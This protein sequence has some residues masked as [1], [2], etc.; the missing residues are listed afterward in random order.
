MLNFIKRYWTGFLAILL[1]IVSVYFIYEKL[2]QKKIPSYLV[3]GTGHIDGDLI[4]L[5]VKYPSR[6][7]K[8]TIDD[9]DKIKKG[10]LIAKLKSKEYEAKKEQIQKEIEAQQKLLKAKEIELNISKTTI[11][12]K[13]LKAKYALNSAQNSL[14]AFKKE[15][16]L[17]KNV[18][19]Q[20]KKDYKRV[21]NLY[22]D[23]LIE[24][25][26]LEIAKLKLKTEN[27][28]LLS[29]LEK[30]KS[31]IES[32]K[33][34]KSN[35]IDAQA[36]QKN[37]DILKESINALTFK[38][39]TLKKSKQE[40]EVILDEMKLY[41][42]IDG[43]VVEKI[44][45]VGEVLNSGMSVATLIDPKSLYLKIFVDTIKNGK[46]KIGDKALIFL[47]AY[48]NDPIKARVTKIAQ[49]AEFTP[50]EVNVRSD[51]IQ[52]V[53]AVYLKPLKPNPLL[54]LGLPAI[55]VISINGKKLPKSLN[56]LPKL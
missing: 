10:M 8:I 47:D 4:N 14:N 36:A 19:S 42:P 1:I 52:R 33:I 23:R 15:I 56:E 13:L 54:K 7:E 20:A 16:D 22:K 18:L 29:M 35:L 12:Q 11:S 38:I 28:K 2:H 5:N 27:D 17:Q 43:Y 50:K 9:G 26:K 6:V 30:Q 49:K 44:A 31:L 34:A 21:K 46:I 24:K 3:V 37:I 53:Y 41:S 40:I 48:P 25:R 32:I 51:R 55:G 45:N 39:E